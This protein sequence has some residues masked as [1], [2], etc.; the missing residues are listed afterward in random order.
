MNSS[1]INNGTE[2]VIKKG[3]VDCV[4]GQIHYRFKT[5]EENKTP[6]VW[7]HQTTKFSQETCPNPCILLNS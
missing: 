2:N 5:G 7:L 4:A 3:Y 1:S 6:I